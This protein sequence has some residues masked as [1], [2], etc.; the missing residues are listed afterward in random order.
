[1]RKNAECPESEK[2]DEF[3]GQP[4]E[5]YVF[6]AAF[7]ATPYVPRDD[8]NQVARFVNR[9][10]YREEVNKGKVPVVTDLQTPSP[11]A[12]INGPAPLTSQVETAN[13]ILMVGSRAK[14]N[15]RKHAFRQLTQRKMASTKASVA[16]RAAE[17]KGRSGDTAKVYDAGEE[18]DS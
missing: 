18:D 4:Y 3:K 13:T 15:G 2:P 6:E 8:P 14:Y 11:V 1:M 16:A 5:P 12:G 10:N 7:D 9:A 17:T